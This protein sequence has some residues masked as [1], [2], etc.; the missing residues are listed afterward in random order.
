[1]NSKKRMKLHAGVVSGKVIFS[2]PMPSNVIVCW[3]GLV[4]R[5]VATAH[6]NVDMCHVV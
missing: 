6:P 4:K 1:M 2:R 5:I 3:R